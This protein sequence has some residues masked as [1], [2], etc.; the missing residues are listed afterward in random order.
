MWRTV[1]Y[2]AW[3][4]QAASEINLVVQLF[5][6]TAAFSTRRLAMTIAARSMWW[7]AT[8]RPQRTR[9]CLTS[10][11]LMMRRTPTTLPLRAAKVC[12]HPYL[13][14]ETSEHADVQSLGCVQHRGLRRLG[15]IND[16]A[17]APRNSVL[18]DMDDT[19]PSWSTL[20]VICRDEISLS[21]SPPF[22]PVLP[23]RP[24][25]AQARQ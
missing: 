18:T 24:H 9:R 25:A 21:G 15:Q 14:G 7:T 10:R 20:A 1:T 6:L 4:D 16:P 5:L 13:A 11:T 12:I 23:L 19:P 17:A 8:R 22:A 2:E 3:E